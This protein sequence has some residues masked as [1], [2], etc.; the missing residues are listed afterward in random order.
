MENATF[1]PQAPGAIRPLQRSRLLQLP[2]EILIHIAEDESLE[3]EDLRSLALTSS[4]LSNVA[5]VPFYRADNFFTF[6]QAIRDADVGMLERCKRFGAMPPCIFKENFPCRCIAYR[7]TTHTTPLRL[8][9]ENL[10]ED[11]GSALAC[12]DVLRWLLANF[13]GS[14]GCAPGSDKVAFIDPVL[15]NL[16]QDNTVGTE[17]VK[18]IC[19]MTQLLVSAG[20][21]FRFTLNRD[22]P[23]SQA[24]ADFHLPLFFFSP[25]TYDTCHIV[26]LAIKS[27]CPPSFLEL[28]LQEFQRRRH[29]VTDPDCESY[30]MLDAWISRGQPAWFLQTDMRSL[31]AV[32]H[33]DLVDPLT[34]WEEAYPGEVADIFERKIELLTRYGTVDTNE[35]K[36]LDA[37][38][39]TLRE[40]AAKGIRD[41]KDCWVKLC[42]SVQPFAADPEMLEP[43]FDP[44]LGTNP[45][46]LHRFEI[47]QNWDPW[48]GWHVNQELHSLWVSLREPL[49]DFANGTLIQLGR[50]SLMPRWHHVNLD[51]W[52]DMVAELRIEWQFKG[53]WDMEIHYE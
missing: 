40:I 3:K 50:Y 41:S 38:L 7:T 49:N 18:V 9:A 48:R 53:P 11:E 31:L 47:D 2:A 35:R 20:Y 8:L 22:K 37:V 4:R 33:A 28:V 25:G 10:I 52:F 32:L 44:Y 23:L 15:T 46:R 12:L 13:H 39:G 1:L 19:E 45:T 17:K 36:L 6:S 16:L 21:G 43:D 42:L 5:T 27:H 14:E 26:E 34:G 29:Q 24:P 30:Q 51:E